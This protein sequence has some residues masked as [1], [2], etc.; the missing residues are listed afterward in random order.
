VRSEFVLVLLSV[1]AGVL[2]VGSLVAV[3]THRQKL[4][5]EAA[6]E[7]QSAIWGC[8]FYPID[9]DQIQGGPL[10]VSAAE[11]HWE[12]GAPGQ[13]AGFTEMRFGRD[14]AR[15]DFPVMKRG[16]R[17]FRG[18]RVTGPAGASLTGIVCFESVE[19]LARVLAE[20][21]WPVLATLTA[22][23]G[24]GLQEG[25]EEIVARGPAVAYVFPVRRYA[26]VVRLALVGAVVLGLGAVGVLNIVLRLAGSHS[27]DHSQGVA[28][29]SAG[30]LG[31]ISGFVVGLLG[32][33]K[34]G[35][36]SATEQ[37]P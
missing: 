11:L 30:L 36:R 33:R 15:V 24:R 6:V 37:T 35:P 26:A 22:P 27:T 7:Q 32:L 5:V 21:G 10:T 1:P 18:L 14:H 25:A 17:T 3:Y 4:V 23:V 29:G 13:E 16:L 28:F 2:L 31:L 9:V 20:Q 12:P 8:W 19:A 34:P